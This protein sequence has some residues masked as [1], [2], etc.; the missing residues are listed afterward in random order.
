MRRAGGRVSKLKRIRIEY[1]RLG[2]MVLRLSLL[3]YTV[4]SC[5]IIYG[6]ATTR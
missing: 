5:I 2:V 4:Y 3:W 1:G 6:S